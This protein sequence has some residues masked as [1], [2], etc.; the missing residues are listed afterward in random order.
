MMRREEC[1]GYKDGEEM[2]GEGL[3]EEEGAGTQ[4]RK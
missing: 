2:E 4:E 3:V 1:Q